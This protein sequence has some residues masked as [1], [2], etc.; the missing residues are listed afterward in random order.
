MNKIGKNTREFNLIQQ[1]LVDYVEPILGCRSRAEDIVQEVIIRTIPNE[2][3]CIPKQG[4]G[5][6]YKAVK[7]LAIDFIRRSAMEKRHQSTHIISWIEPSATPNP[8]TVLAQQK[9]IS[10]IVNALDKLPEKEKIAIQ[11]HRIE[12]CS[13]SEIAQHLNVSNATV[14]RLIKKGFLTI[15]KELTPKTD[16]EK[17]DD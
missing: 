4:V 10:K 5:Y 3:S 14:H 17:D 12:G 16:K 15:M 7:N 6:L 13:F 8:E 1:N 9:E 11:K 2:Q